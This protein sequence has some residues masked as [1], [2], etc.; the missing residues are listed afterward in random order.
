MDYYRVT[1]AAIHVFW[2]MIWRCCSLQVRNSS[3]PLGERRRRSVQ[4]L[5]WLALKK[6][7]HTA[8]AGGSQRCMSTCSSG[9][10]APVSWRRLSP[11]WQIKPQRNCSIFRNGKIREN[12]GLSENSS[13]YSSINLDEVIYSDPV[14]IFYMTMAWIMLSNFYIII[15]GL[16]VED[17]MKIIMRVT[18]LGDSQHDQWSVRKSPIHAWLGL[19][20]PT[21][22]TEREG[23]QEESEVSLRGGRSKNANGFCRGYR[24]PREKCRPVMS[25]GCLSFMLFLMLFMI[26]FPPKVFISLMCIEST[27]ITVCFQLQ[28]ARTVCSVAVLFTATWGNCNRGFG[29]KR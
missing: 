7:D 26:S 14:S 9:T 25:R 2:R 3:L 24:D 28:Q 12:A 21:R 13:S 5:G 8:S 23:K 15:V 17:E 20:R 11:S 16:K 27:K 18:V 1:S 29:R 6:R 19:C 22:S 10:S 4:E